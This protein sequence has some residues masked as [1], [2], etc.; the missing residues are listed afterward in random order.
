MNLLYTKKDAK[1]KIFKT[2]KKLVDNHIFYLENLKKAMLRVLNSYKFQLSQQ[3]LLIHPM[4]YA[5]IKSIL[6]IGKTLTGS[7]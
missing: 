7:N 4:Q 3:L 5:L 6:P 1:K 2:S